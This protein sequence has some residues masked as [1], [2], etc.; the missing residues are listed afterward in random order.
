M[1]ADDLR[2]RLNSDGATGRLA[3]DALFSMTILFERAA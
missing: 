2:Q 1:K 3:L